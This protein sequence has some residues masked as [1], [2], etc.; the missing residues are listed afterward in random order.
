M[1]IVSTRHSSVR[2]STSVSYRHNEPHQKSGDVC[3]HKQNPTLERLRLHGVVSY[4][5]VRWMKAAQAYYG[6]ATHHHSQERCATI[7]NP[8]LDRLE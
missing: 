7:G 5:I 8:T 6:G 2:Y 4:R 3:H 1:T